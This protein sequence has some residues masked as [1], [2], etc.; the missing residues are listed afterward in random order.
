[1]WARRKT[2]REKSGR[3][4]H[5][6]RPACSGRRHWT[7]MILMIMRMMPMKM[8][9]MTKM[10]KI[11]NFFP[12]QLRR[13]RST[14]GLNDSD[15]Y[16]ARAPS[17]RQIIIIAMIIIKMLMMIIMIIK[18]LL[19]MTMTGTASTG[20]Q[21]LMQVLVSKHSTSLPGM[22]WS[23]DFYYYYDYCYHD[24]DFY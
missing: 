9:M 3:R 1:M 22:I 15:H 24:F 18:N 19:I 7:M 10:T 23:Y 14:H 21:Q 11:V 8:T 5:L 6:C 4:N 20:T 13:H 16:P 12:V 2:A 17:N